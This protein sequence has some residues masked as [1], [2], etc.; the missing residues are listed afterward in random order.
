MCVQLQLTI[1][2][3]INAGPVLPGTGPR[4]VPPRTSSAVAPRS[5]L[6]SHDSAH[7]Q[8]RPVVC[9]PTTSSPLPHPRHAGAR[10]ASGFCPDSTV[11]Y[12]PR[13][14]VAPTGP[15]PA[16]T[17]TA[18]TLLPLPCSAL[19]NVCIKANE[20]D[21]AQDVYKQML[22]EGCAPNLVSVVGARP[23]TRQQGAGPAGYNGATALA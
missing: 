23:Q 4:T 12:M 19:M 8:S 1:L 3:C 11:A 9:Y 20:L 18:P 14:D 21:L 5:H 15:H 22:E 13:A 7:L 17:R 2:V 10:L 16:P 6:A